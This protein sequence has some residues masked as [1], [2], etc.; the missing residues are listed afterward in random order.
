MP[1]HFCVKMCE[2][3]SGLTLPLQHSEFSTPPAPTLS[4][5]AGQSSAAGASDRLCI[6]SVFLCTEPDKAEWL[7]I[8][9]VAGRKHAQRADT[10]GGASRKEGRG[11][12]TLHSS[13]MGEAC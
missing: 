12:L 13:K 1:S 6:V 2:F 10:V 4:L 8:C 5:H 11:G 3:K 9:R 7:L